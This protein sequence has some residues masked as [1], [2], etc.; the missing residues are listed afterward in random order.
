MASSVRFGRFRWDRGG[1][2]RLMSK[3]PVQSMLRGKAEAVRSAADG[4]L[5]EGGYE[6]PG[7]EV[8]DFDGVLANGFVVRTKTYQAHY[9]Q[10]KRKTLE[11]ALG[12]A[13][14]G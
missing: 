13:N 7:H 11:K 8:K 1:Y 6:L 5:S 9:S 10:A 2:A 4:L 12:S 14:G 3:P